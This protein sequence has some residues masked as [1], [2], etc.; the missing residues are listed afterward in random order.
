MKRI[1]KTYRDG[2]FKKRQLYLIMASSVMNKSEM[3]DFFNEN[4]KHDVVNMSKDTVANVRLGLARVLRNH[5]KL[6][7]GSFI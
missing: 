3:K 4:F 6:I 7:D 5:F 2:T 1:N